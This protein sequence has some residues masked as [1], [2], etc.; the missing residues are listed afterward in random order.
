MLI[1]S[2]TDNMLRSQQRVDLVGLM[3]RTSQGLFSFLQ[4]LFYRLDYVPAST[5]TG[6]HQNI[7]YYINQSSIYTLSKIEQEAPQNVDKLMLF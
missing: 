7:A 3:F 2:L 1:S 4:I 5:A 6:Y